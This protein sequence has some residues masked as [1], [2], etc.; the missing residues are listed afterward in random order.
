M[1]GDASLRRW[2]PRLLVL[3][4]ALAAFA[5]YAA[6]L[7][8]QEV[9]DRA[10]AYR[11]GLLAHVV[12]TA[13]GAT[14]VG[15]RIAPRTAYLGLVGTAAIYSVALGLPVFML[16]PAVLFVTYS[17]GLH[18]TRRQGLPYVGL[19]IVALLVLLLVG[20]SFPGWSSVLL[21]AMLLVAAW[22]LGAGVRRW[23]VL[24]AELSDRAAELEQ[25][26]LELAS[27]AVAAERVRI[28]REL[29][30]VVAHSMSVV[31][32]H[33][34]SARL[35]V[36]TNPDAERAA[37]EV[38]ERASRDALGEMRRLVTVLRHEDADAASREPAPRVTDLHDMVA[39]V[40]QAG[41]TVDVRTSGDL[42]Q[43]PPGPSL[44]AYRVIQEALTNVVRH[45]GPTRARLVVEA[46]DEMLAICVE[47][48]GPPP[49]GERAAPATGGGHGTIGMRERVELYDGTLNVG[50]T[51]TGGWRVEARIPFERSS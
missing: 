20:S 47:N 1:R 36:G 48:D 45:A 14:V 7:L 24:A 34:G 6:N 35:A 5:I 32:M 3:D 23:Q 2:P 49:R 18:L 39:T 8:T 41:V 31:A 10:S 13:H 21:Y 28:A 25:A 44:S 29:H 15:R 11:Y 27:H 40:A 43:L 30:D 17:L 46:V 16:G 51:P 12:A 19:G 4:L 50:P 9:V 42:T 26:R 33:A 37:L 38:I 22:F